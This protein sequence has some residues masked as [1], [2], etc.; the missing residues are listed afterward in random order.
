M[1]F[2]DLLDNSTVLF[3][4]SLVLIV[5][6]LTMALFASW[7]NERR[8]LTPVTALF[9]FIAIH[10]LGGYFLAFTS[11]LQIAR[12]APALEPYYNRAL[13]ILSLGAGS[14]FLGYSVCPLRM[15][16]R[17]IGSLEKFATSIRTEDLQRRCRFFVGLSVV[18]AACGL[19]AIGRIPLFTDPS[20]RYVDI[21]NPSYGWTGFVVNRS[22]ELIQIPTAFLLLL[23]LRKENVGVNLAYS[24]IGLFTSV[25]TAT[26][27]P[28]ADVILIVAL[29]IL[30]RRKLAV[31]LFC[32]IFMV[33]AYMGSQLYFLQSAETAED[34]IAAG[35]G[36]GLPELRDFA[37]VIANDTEPHWGLTVLVAALPIPGFI[38]DFTKANGLRSVTLN[39]VGIPLDA[40]HGGLRLTCLGEFY[41]NWRLTGV[42]IGGLLVGAFYSWFGGAMMLASRSGDI[43][44]ECLVASIWMLISFEFYLSG[45]GIAGMIKVL[46]ALLIMLYLVPGRVG[47]FGI[48][49]P[50]VQRLT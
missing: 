37:H 6:T 20:Q 17:M 31:F 35:F 3:V 34:S 36:G 22:R 49:P 24:V 15:N 33:F 30:M 11:S 9:L 16:E 42:L 44:L 28:L 13:A 21:F 19:V 4:V 43:R 27:T 32:G 1:L 38:S 8:I 48:E 45:T 25:L 50:P 14:I 23:V 29:V 7:R 10:V 41:I 18:L 46:A 47:A 39:A 12:A 26:R 40:P 2:E 5:T